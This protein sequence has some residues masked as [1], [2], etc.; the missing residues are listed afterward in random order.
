MR[1]MKFLI[2]LGVATPL[3]LGWL[4]W[5]AATLPPPAPLISPTGL[6]AVVA[7]TRRPAPTVKKAAASIGGKIA[8]R[9]PSPPTLGNKG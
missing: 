1:I 3:V 4:L 2:Y 5:E 6:N 8:T 7:E 9:S